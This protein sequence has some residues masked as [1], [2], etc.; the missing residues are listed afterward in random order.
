ML[1]FICVGSREIGDEIPHGIR[2]HVIVTRFSAG[3]SRDQRRFV[4]S[5]RDCRKRRRMKFK[6][7]DFES[8]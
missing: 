6:G 4:A 8:A 3:K 7:G 2:V 1:G 5:R